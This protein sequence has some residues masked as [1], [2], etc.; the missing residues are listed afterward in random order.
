MACSCAKAIVSHGRQLR[1][2][3][4]VHAQPSFSERRDPVIDRGSIRG[5]RCARMARRSSSH[6]RSHWRTRTIPERSDAQK[7]WRLPRAS[8]GVPLLRDGELIGAIIIYRQ[9]GREPFTDETDRAGDDFRRPGGDRHRERPPV[10]RGAGAHHRARA[11]GRGAARARR[12]VAG[13]QLDARPADGARHHRRQ[14]GAA[15][16]H[17]S[18]RHLCARREARNSSC[19]RPTA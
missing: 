18:G 14:G 5:S 2:G 1:H 12:G 10:R 8:L 16:R 4:D 13:G 15:F 3:A 7:H 11:L 19:A 17:R 6:S 9:R